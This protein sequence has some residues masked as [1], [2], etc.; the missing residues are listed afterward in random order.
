MGE[1]PIEGDQSVGLELGQSDV[2][3]VKGVGPS[4]LAGDLPC[5]ILKDAV[6]EQPNPRP[7]RV[8]ESSAGILFGHLTAVRCLVEERE[9]LPA[10]KR[11]SQDVMFIADH[12]LR[13]GQVNGALWT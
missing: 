4:E 5:D 13:L 12:G 3:G 2:L 11:R 1:L 9:H 6:S 10:K 7:A 8:V